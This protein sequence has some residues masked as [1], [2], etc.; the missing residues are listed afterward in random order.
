M[1]RL[2]QEL[3]QTPYRIWPLNTGD[4]LGGKS[5]AKVMKRYALGL[6]AVRKLKKRLFLRLA[7][8][9]GVSRSRICHKG[10]LSEI[11]FSSGF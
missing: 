4:C 3:P 8:L 11:I 7:F 2:A 10:S 5:L 9:E 6:S 1:S